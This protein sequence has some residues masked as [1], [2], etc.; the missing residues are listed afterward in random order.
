[1]D[2]FRILLYQ[3]QCFRGSGITGTQL[4]PGE[5][6][7]LMHQLGIEETLLFGLGLVGFGHE[8]GQGLLISNSFIYSE[9][10][11][12]GKVES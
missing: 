1:V 9:G 5:F 7:H 4:L 11:G 3:V 12:T 10:T 6:G 2:L 8:G